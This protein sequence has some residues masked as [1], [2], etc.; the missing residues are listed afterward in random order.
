MKN[1]QKKTF[2]F[3]AIVERERKKNRKLASAN[4]KKEKTFLSL[5][6]ELKTSFMK[7]S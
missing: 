5:F 3:N 6:S 4:R 2:I 1:K 7:A